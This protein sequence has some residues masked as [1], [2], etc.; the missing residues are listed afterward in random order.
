MSLM[1]EIEKM[2]NTTNTSIN[3]RIVNVGGQNLY[4]EGIKNVVDLKETEMTFQLKKALLKVVGRCMKV[5]YL[6][7]TTCIISGEI[8][9]VVTQ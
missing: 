2:L 8:I 1:S 3:Y 4:I 6:D 5:K 7:K 9:S